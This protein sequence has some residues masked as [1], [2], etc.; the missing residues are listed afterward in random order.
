M[1]MNIF[2]LF[3]YSIQNKS[4]VVDDVKTSGDSGSNLLVDN[5]GSLL[6]ENLNNKMLAPPLQDLANVDWRNRRPVG[7]A[8]GGKENQVG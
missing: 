1:L 3:Q 8:N 4:E 5:L 6:E 2:F 7:T